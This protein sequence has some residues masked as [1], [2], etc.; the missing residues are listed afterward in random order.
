MTVGEIHFA[1]I[2]GKVKHKSGNLQRK[3]GL[4]T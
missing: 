4:P 1:G 2:T 3:T